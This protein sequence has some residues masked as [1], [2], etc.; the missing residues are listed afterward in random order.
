VATNLFH[1][2]DTFFHNFALAKDEEASAGVASDFFRE[3]YLMHGA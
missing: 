3:L 2:A 1:F